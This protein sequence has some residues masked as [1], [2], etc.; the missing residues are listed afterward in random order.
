MLG[1]VWVKTVSQDIGRQNDK[2]KSSLHFFLNTKG[3]TFFFKKKCHFSIHVNGEVV[4][5]IFLR[6]ALKY[7]DTIYCD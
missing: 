6:A 3:K 1:L 5:K 4:R 2:I 7:M